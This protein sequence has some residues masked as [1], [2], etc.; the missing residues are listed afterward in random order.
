MA[1]LGR[2]AQIREATEKKIMKENLNAWNE[3]NHDFVERFN[4]DIDEEINQ[5]YDISNVPDPD[6]YNLDGS[7]LKS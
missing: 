1:A 6:A 2:L 7:P 3:I 5:R 4:K